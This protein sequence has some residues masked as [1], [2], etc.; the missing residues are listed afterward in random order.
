M[1]KLTSDILDLL[2]DLS[3]Y[4]DRYSDYEDGDYGISVPN[5]ELIHYSRIVGLIERIEGE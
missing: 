3:E 2:I 5:L 1:D 4:F